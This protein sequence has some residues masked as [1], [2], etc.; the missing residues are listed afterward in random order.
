M[1]CDYTKRSYLLPEGCKDLIDVLKLKQKQKFAPFLFPKLPKYWKKVKPGKQPAPLPPAWK[2]FFDTYWKLIYGVAKRSYLLP[3]GCKDLI[4]V[5]KLKHKLT[6]TKSL[7]EAAMEKVKRQ[8]N[9]KQF[10]IFDLYVVKKWPVLK[11]AQTLGV[12][13]GH[14]NLANLHISALL[15]REIKKLKGEMF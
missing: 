10:Q 3:E 8:V 7:L 12:N 6:E 15:K 13:V 11:V 4:D 1:D 5:L 14:I 2:D 9:P